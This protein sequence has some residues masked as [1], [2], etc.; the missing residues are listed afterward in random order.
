MKRFWGILLLTVGL[1]TT[2]AGFMNLAAAADAANS[3]SFFDPGRGD[4]MA[5]TSVIMI[6]T[7]VVLFVIGIVMLTAKQKAMKK[8]VFD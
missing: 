5:T 3:P 1:L 6:G 8:Q 2:I 4:A 7:G